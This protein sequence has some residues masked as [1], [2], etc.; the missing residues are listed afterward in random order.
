MRPDFIPNLRTSLIR[1]EQT[2]LQ[3]GHCG[4]CLQKDV[5]SGGRGPS[6]GAASAVEVQGWLWGW[7]RMP[8]AE[9]IGKHLKTRSRFGV[10]KK[11]RKELRFPARANWRGRCSEHRERSRK[12]TFGLRGRVSTASLPSSWPWAAGLTEV[13]ST[14]ETKTWW[15]DQ[16]HS[17]LCFLFPRLNLTVV[18]LSTFS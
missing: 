2:T 16:L 7:R 13:I 5:E 14:F 9:I 15:S 10:R 3:T 1:H 8:P 18:L 12:G 17:S 11:S 4:G 6:V